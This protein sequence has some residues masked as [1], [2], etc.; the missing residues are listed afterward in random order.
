MSITAISHRFS[1]SDSTTKPPL[2][3]NLGCFDSSE[4]GWINTDITP[5]I[6]ISR[7][8][9]SAWILWKCGLMDRA[10]YDQHRAKIFDRVTYLNMAKRFPFRDNQVEAYF[11]SHALE[12]LYVYQTK[13][14]LREIYRTLAPGGFVRIVLPDLDDAMS[15]Y[16]AADPTVFLERIFQASEPSM[17]KNHHHWMYTSPYMDALLQEAGFSR[18]WVQGYQRTQYS[19]F[20]KLDNRPE[21]SFFIEAQK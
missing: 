11:T 13:K 19:P 1:L 3:V 18:I 10:R 14:V 9:G 20:L 5:H 8:P 2:R 16:D 12:H 15:D 21:G 7:I 6:W 17:K 4:E